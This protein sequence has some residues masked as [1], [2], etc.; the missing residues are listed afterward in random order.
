[1]KPHA[2]VTLL[3]SI[4][5]LAACGPAA[6]PAPDR[7]TAQAT[8]PETAAPVRA[9]DT[10]A[11]SATPSPE[12]G[13]TPTA[14]IPPTPE[15]TP[16]GGKSPKIAL[17]ARDAQ[18]EPGLYAGDLYGGELTRLL[19]LNPDREYLAWS[20]LGWSADGQQIAY[21][22]RSPATGTAIFVYSLDSGTSDFVVKLYPD[23]MVWSLRFSPDGSQLAYSVAGNSGSIHQ[24]VDLAS[25][26]ITDLEA[27]VPGDWP[28]G[29]VGV[30]EWVDEAVWRAYEGSRIA[31]PEAGFFTAYDE[32]TGVLQKV[33]LDGSRLETLATFEPNADGKFIWNGPLTLQI[34][35]DGQSAV[36]EGQVNGGVNWA[37]P[38]R[39]AGLPYAFTQADFAPYSY[40]AD[41]RTNL[42]LAPQAQNTRF[43]LA[44]SPDSRYYVVSVGQYLDLAPDE[45]P[46]Y[47][48][49]ANTVNPAWRLEVIDAQ[50]GQAAFT[51]ALPAGLT[52]A[53]MLMDTLYG[54][55]VVWPGD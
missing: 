54:L 20:T 49:F 37:F 41:A 36:L 50:S 44:W 14:T 6:A 25:K 8:Q 19:P 3:L 46:D 42:E 13:A 12:P 33:S 53:I 30:S 39:F 32:R 48:A 38:V 18:G 29:P 17:Y 28:I 45:D 5:L 34:A 2:C 23:D 40:P 26:Q 55:D 27:R 47:L 21:I 1:M 11:P 7:P 35:P 9:S 16:L 51:Y 4:L 43:G 31:Y 24:V 22:D 10:P 52:P 15:P